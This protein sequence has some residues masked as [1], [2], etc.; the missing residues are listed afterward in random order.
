GNNLAKQIGT[1]GDK[2]SDRSGML[3]LISPPGYGKTTLM[4]YLADRLGM[5]FVRVNGPTL[6][7]EVSGLDPAQAPHRAAREELEKLNLG[8]AMGRNVMLYLDD[9]QHLSPEFLQKFISLADGTRRIDAV[10]NGQATSIDLRGKRFCI[11]MAGNPYTEQGERFQIPDMLANRADTYN[12]GD[13]LSGREKLFADSYLENALTAH[14][15]TQPLAERSREEI[16]T[17][18]R[19]AAGEDEA[20]PSSIPSAVEVGE[21]LRRMGT[22]R[23]LLMKVNAAYVASAAQDDSYRTEPP[24]KLQGSYR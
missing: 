11:V 9:I 23:D 21:L 17:A 12:L 19:I 6:G 20:L 4:E 14:P 2:R 18:L 1:V 15:L 8:L 13:V 3:L 24:F 10:V 5:I 7:H 16:R 22:V